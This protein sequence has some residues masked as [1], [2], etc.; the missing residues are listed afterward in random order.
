MWIDMAMR[1]SVWQYCDMCDMSYSVSD[2]SMK[3]ARGVSR[4]S[5]GLVLMQSA[6]L[7]WLGFSVVFLKL[8]LTKEWE[9][10]FFFSAERFT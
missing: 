3:A 9:S 7:I 2:A 1:D 5:T 10:F 6:E 8:K 4:D